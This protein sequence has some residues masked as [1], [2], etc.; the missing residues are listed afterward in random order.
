MKKAAF[1][2]AAVL[3]LLVLP[4]LVLAADGCMPEGE[5][6]AG[7]CKKMDLDEEQA[8]KIEKLMLQHRLD[9]IDLKAEKKKLHLMV[10]EELLKDKIDRAS[11]DK[12]FGKISNV[13][14]QLRENKIDFLLS[15]KKELKP[16]QWKMFL[17]RHM[18]EGCGCGY[19]MDCM[20]KMGGCRGPQVHKKHGC[21]S[22]VGAREDCSGKCFGCCGHGK[23]MGEKFKQGGCGRKPAQGCSPGCKE[24]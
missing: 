3:F 24:G 2:T 23:M 19:G 7:Q 14:K 21:C 13:Q 16:E 12:L 1:S 15:A 5:R 22:G 9:N 4:V 17:K 10:H 11:L 8:L 6:K 18:T 20:C